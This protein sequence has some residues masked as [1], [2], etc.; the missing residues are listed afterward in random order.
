MIFFSPNELPWQAQ[1]NFAPYTFLSQTP[2]PPPPK[3]E[4]LGEEKKVK[5]MFFSLTEAA[6]DQWKQD[7][8]WP[9]LNWV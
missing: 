8:P 4:R 6:I 9:L 1:G 7:V 3:K 5:A 2:P